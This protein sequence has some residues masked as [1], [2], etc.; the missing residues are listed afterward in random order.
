MARYLLALIT[1]PI[2]IPRATKA[3]STWRTPLDNTTG[4]GTRKRLKNKGKW[5]GLFLEGFCV[6]AQGDE[7][8]LK[9]KG[10]GQ[11]STTPD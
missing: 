7:A 6:R 3:Q 11:K 5:P 10:S 2:S 9:G 4:Q 8:L 1:L